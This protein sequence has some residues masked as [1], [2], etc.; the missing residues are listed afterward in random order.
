MSQDCVVFFEFDTISTKSWM[1]RDSN[2]RPLDRESSSV[3]T[4]SDFHHLSFVDDS[5]GFEKSDS[6]NR[7]VS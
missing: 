6:R 1:S 2:Q 5:K 7:K 3:S 4:R